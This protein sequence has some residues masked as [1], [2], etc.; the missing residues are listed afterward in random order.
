M[1]YFIACNKTNNTTNI[2]ELYFKEVTRLHGIPRPIVSD[3]DTKFLNH[4]WIIIWKKLGMKLSYSTACHPQTDGQTEV[5]NRTLGILLRVLIKPQ[6]RA[7]DLLR[8]HA[9][10]A[11]NKTQSRTTGI[12]PFKVLYG[13]DP[14]GPLD[15]VP[16]PLDKRPSA[17]TD[18]RV[19][20]IK[21]WH[22]RVSDKVEKINL[23][24]SAQANKHRMRKVF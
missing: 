14:W 21:K 16:R 9:E 11:Y 5:T 4:F 13:I 22:E 24:Y 8:P 1:A 7:W 17:D 2:I 3:R 12:S 19:E 23:I 15:L 6:S 20:E 18:Q 10:F